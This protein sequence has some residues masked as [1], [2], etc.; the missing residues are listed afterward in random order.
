MPSYHL[1]KGDPMDNDPQP[2]NKFDMASEMGNLL[3]VGAMMLL[4]GLAIVIAL[5]QTGGER[6]PSEPEQRH[7]VEDYDD[8]DDF[9]DDRERARRDEDCIPDRSDAEE[10]FAAPDCDGHGRTGSG[11]FD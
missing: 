11:L 9:E 8:H 10:R 2:K 5:S 6:E 3:I 4:A 1:V 7:F